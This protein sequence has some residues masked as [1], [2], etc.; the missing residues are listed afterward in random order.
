M[1]QIQWF[2]KNCE[3]LGKKNFILFIM[4]KLEYNINIV[5]LLYCT[6]ECMDDNI[7]INIIDYI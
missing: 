6:H 4:C 5:L 1:V 2:L 3:F 7:N